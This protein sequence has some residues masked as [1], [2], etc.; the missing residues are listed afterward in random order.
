MRKA[1]SQA[2][3]VLLPFGQGPFLTRSKVL[4]VKHCIPSSSKRRSAGNREHE[5]RQNLMALDEELDAVALEVLEFAVEA[6]HV[7][8]RLDQF[9]TAKLPERSR[10]QIQEWIEVGRVLVNGISAKSSAKLKTGQEVLVEIPPLE[11][12]EPQAD[13]SIALE[14]LFEDAHLL[15]LNKQR[16]LVVHPAHGNWD[17]TLV[18]A[19]L[20]HCQDL[21]GIRGVEKPGI[22]H[23]LDKDTSGVMVVAKS[24]LA[25]HSLTSQFADRTVT[26]VY[27]ALVHGVPNPSRGRINQALARHAVDRVR[28]AVNPQ[29]RTSI[30][31]YEVLEDFG[32]YALVELHI[33]TG[34]THQIRVHMTWLGNP[35]IGDHLY[36]KRSNPFGFEGQ[37]LH[38]K[39]LG[40]RHPLTHEPMEFTCRPPAEYR[41]VLEQLRQR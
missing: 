5:Q 29:G 4:G 28:M 9:L 31:D 34:R 17:G 21:S 30:S 27:E 41:A 26:K 15:V 16:G 38:C 23:R 13:P 14:V 19:L 6:E 33:H 2:R 35:L 12:A 8:T 22:V 10:S 39:R 32:T 25:H 7:G 20:A 37:A 1:E 36:G 11:P 3:S 18:N 40:F 24:D